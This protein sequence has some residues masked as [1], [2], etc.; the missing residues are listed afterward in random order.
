MYSFMSLFIYV[1]SLCISFFLYVMLFFS[2]LVRY[3]FIA[4]LPPC[5]FL[6]LFLPVCM[7]YFFRYFVRSLFMYCFLQVFRPFVR[8]SVLSLCIPFVVCLCHPPRMSLFV[9][10]FIV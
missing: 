1:V 10:L 3:F 5:L 4:S 7:G 8:S 9:Y 2:Y 6:S